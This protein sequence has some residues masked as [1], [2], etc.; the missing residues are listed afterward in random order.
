MFAG[1]VKC[2]CHSR[3]TIVNDEKVWLIEF[4]SPMCGSCKEFSPIWTD[5]ESS[6]R[7]KIN[8]AKINIDDKDGLKIAQDVGALDEGIPHIRLFHK[9]SDSTG[10]SL[11][12]GQRFDSQTLFIFTKF[13]YCLLEESQMKQKDIMKALKK[14]LKGFSFICLQFC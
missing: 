6:L 9:E 5:I 1:S 12:L 7:N 11:H 13:I 14:Q 3:S 10:I 2:L 8:T 4:Y